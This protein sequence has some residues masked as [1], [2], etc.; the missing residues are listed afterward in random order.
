MPSFVAPCP[1]GHTGNF[2]THDGYHHCFCGLH[3]PEFK[4]PPVPFST[5]DVIDLQD[6]TMEEQ[7]KLNDQYIKQEVDEQVAAR[8]EDAITD[9]VSALEMELTEKVEHLED[10][11][12]IVDPEF[13][14]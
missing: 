13:D 5:I 4:L 8:V 14:R 7:Q 3:I 6:I 10:R 9:A 1:R 2:V 11:L 12:M